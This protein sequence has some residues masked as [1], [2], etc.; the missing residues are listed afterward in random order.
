[1][2]TQDAIPGRQDA[3]PGDGLAVLLL[4]LAVPSLAALLTIGVFLLAMR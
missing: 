3:R 1:M 2:T 4:D